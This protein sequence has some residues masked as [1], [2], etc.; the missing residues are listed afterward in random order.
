M[1][2]GLELCSAPFLSHETV[3]LMQ[4]LRSDTPGPMRGSVMRLDTQYRSVYQ[5]TTV[6]M[7]RGRKFRQEVQQWNL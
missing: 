2:T 1:N 5:I 3:V 6:G 4:A 7:R